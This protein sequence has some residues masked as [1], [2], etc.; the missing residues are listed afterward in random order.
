MGEVVSSFQRRGTLGEEVVED[1]FFGFR[2]RY[3]LL[4]F[5][6]SLVFSLLRP[7]WEEK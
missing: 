4:F 7:R 6:S 2:Q 5:F 1:Q 3:L